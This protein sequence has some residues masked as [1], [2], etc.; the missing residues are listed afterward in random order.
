MPDKPDPTVVEPYGSAP[1]PDVAKG[2]QDPPQKPNDPTGK[3]LT[4]PSD[5]KGG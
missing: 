3:E 5:T 1:R 4:Q 2:R